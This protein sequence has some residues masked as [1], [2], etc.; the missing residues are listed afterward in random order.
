MA[1][2]TCHTTYILSEHSK[3]VNAV[4]DRLF[5][6]KVSSDTIVEGGQTSTIFL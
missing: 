1:K 6:I 4:S 2:K 5:L 3:R